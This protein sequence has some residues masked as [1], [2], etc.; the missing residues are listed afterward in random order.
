[1]SGLSDVN[2]DVEAGGPV[3]ELA[4]EGPGM[5]VSSYDRASS[6]L[7]VALVGAGSIVSLLF[8]VWLTRQI[9]TRQEAVPVEFLQGLADGDEAAGGSADELMEPAMDEFAEIEPDLDETLETVTEAISAQ[10][11]ALDAMAGDQSS[12]GATGDGRG[13]GGG[14][15]FNAI[16]RWQRWQIQFNGADL[17][18]YARQLDGFNIELGAVGGGSEM[19]EYAANLSKESPDRRQGSSDKES[20]LYMTWRHGGLRAADEALLRRAEITT[21]GRLVVQFY[22]S[23]TENKLAL[24]EKKKAG[25]RSVE[26]IRKTVFGIQGGGGGSYE[27][28]VMDQQYR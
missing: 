3:P 7:V 23:A 21:Q 4:F 16:P 11:S 1:M 28:F 10:A 19:V 24:A 27:F 5:R 13:S 12:A 9:L 20:R 17:S 8:L 6:A 25:S 15:D 26:T 18:N 22:P 2:T 14:G